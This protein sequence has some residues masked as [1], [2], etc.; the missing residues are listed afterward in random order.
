MDERTDS[1]LV[2][3]NKLHAR[4]ELSQTVSS[5]YFEPGMMEYLDQSEG[6][7][8]A[9]TGELLLRFEAR[10][11][12]YEGR[13]ERIEK[14]RLLDEVLVRR[15]EK[16]SYN[17]N[18]FE[19]LTTTGKSLGNIPAEL[20]NVIAPLYDRGE[21]HLIKAHVSYVEPI[22]KRSRYAKQA[23]LFVE[24]K[25]SIKKCIETV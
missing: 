12:R 25:L 3:V 8:N 14:V 9:E 21:L 7:F 2:E 11:T 19:L 13:T 10:G 6:L 18:N 16:N 15:D 22:S 20:C 17:V 4:K 1:L 24:M 5:D 23:V